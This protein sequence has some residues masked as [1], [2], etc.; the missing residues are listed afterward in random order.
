M[1][2]QDI[3]KDLVPNEYSC[4]DLIQVKDNKLLSNV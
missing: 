3:G 2:W 4:K 1:R